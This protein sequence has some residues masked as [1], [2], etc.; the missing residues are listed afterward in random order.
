M[1]VTK[2][3]EKLENSAV[4]LTITINK[5]D[6]AAGYD[7]TLTKYSKNLQL[8]GF[9]KG[10][11]PVSVLERKYGDAL[12]NDV[13]GELIEKA[14]EEVFGEFDKEKSENR[15]L[16]YSQPQLDSL[17]QLDVKKDLVF[18]VIYDVMPTVK[19]EDFSGIKIEEP[20]V[21][22][23]DEEMNEE[24]KAIQERNAMVLDKKDSEPAA[25]DDIATIN[26]SELD[27]K[28]EE[29][30][31]SKREGFVFTIGS[32]ENIYKIDDEI[33][34]M[35]KDE[36]KEITKTYADDFADKDIA[37]TTKKIKVTVTALKIRDLPALDDELAQ[38]VNEK[39]KTLDDLKADIKKNLNAAKDN[40][41]KEIKSNSLI[42]QLVEKYPVELP[43]SMLD[44]ELEGRWRMMAQ[45]FQ[46]SVEQ[47]DKLM[48]SSGQKKEDLLNEWSDDAAKMLKGRI[49]VE[50]LLKDS[51]IEVTPEEVEAEYNKI[52]EG[53]GISVEEVKKHYADAVKKEYLIDD[54][55]EQKLYTE[56]FA[57]VKITK[58]EKI[59]FADLF[60]NA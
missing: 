22:I 20:Q 29:I 56:I 40:R 13:A 28:G 41:I 14:L 26:Y 49:I 30:A 59:K 33:I 15:P 3:I 51:K 21:E 2:E 23:T 50:S 57:K 34:G 42:E 6:V 53:A 52:A 5:K 55:K 25:K 58:G 38:D 18:S 31:G 16:A 60:K 10:K 19:V 32:G 35:K 46:C 1:T 4:K 7:E 9:R 12:K 27:D 11:V 36:T 45:R 43:K 54:I 48:A 37:G 47:L 24:L 8:P 44:A 39:Y 17:P